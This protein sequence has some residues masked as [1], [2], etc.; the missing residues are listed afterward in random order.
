MSGKRSRWS[1]L[2]VSLPLVATFTS[3]SCAEQVRYGGYGHLNRRNVLKYDGYGIVELA[4]KQIGTPYRFGG[5]KPGGF[6]CSGLVQYVYRKAG[7]KLP[8]Q[9]GSQFRAM[10]SIR[11]PRPGDL[12]FFKIKGDRISHVGIY[13]GNFKFIHAPRTGKRVGYADIRNRY[14]K[15]RFVG[16]KTVFW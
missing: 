12:L 3:L 6:D 10:Q 14:W 13:A 11:V 2:L 8:R 1:I 15:S 5:S 16:A 4:K 7:Y 9:T